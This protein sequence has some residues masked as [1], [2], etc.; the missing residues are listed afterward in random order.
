MSQCEPLERMENE[1]RKKI[2]SVMLVVFYL[3][4]FMYTLTVI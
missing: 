4:V 2:G 3:K 1:T